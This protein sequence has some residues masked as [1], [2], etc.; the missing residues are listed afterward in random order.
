MSQKR[1]KKVISDFLVYYYTNK[2]GNMICASFLNFGVSIGGLNQ[3][4]VNF[5]PVPIPH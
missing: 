2:V 3:L 1:R 5:I 4:L